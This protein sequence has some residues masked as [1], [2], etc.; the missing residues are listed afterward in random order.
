MYL[1]QT[2]AQLSQSWL[3]LAI[4]VIL[5]GLI[6]KCNRR[7]AILHLGQHGGDTGF[8]STRSSTN[9]RFQGIEGLLTCSQWTTEIYVS[10]P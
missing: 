5:L 2:L 8:T 6:S 3:M 7:L 1:S 10:S 4:F 9:G